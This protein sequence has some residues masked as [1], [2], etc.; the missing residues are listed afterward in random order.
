MKLLALEIEIEKIDPKASQ[1]HLEVEARKAWELQQEGFIREIYFRDDQAT[2]V[3][4][5]EARNKEE[6][7]KRLFELP[8][9]R[10]GLIKFEIIPLRAYPGFE[11]LFKNK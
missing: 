5:L 10:N 11:R 4:V 2:A 6:A 9:V 3:L 8:L 7:K 1:Q